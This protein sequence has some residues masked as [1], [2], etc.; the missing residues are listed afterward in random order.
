MVSAGQTVYSVFEEFIIVGKGPSSSMG[1]ILSVCDNKIIRR[2]N[3]RKELAYT[4]S[5]LLSDNIS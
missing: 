4:N 3:P 1:G 5:S 2:H